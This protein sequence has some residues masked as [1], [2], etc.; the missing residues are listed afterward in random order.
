MIRKQTLFLVAAV[1][2]IGFATQAHAQ[3]GAA[4]VFQ[5]KGANIGAFAIFGP[6]VV[7]ADG[8]EGFA[9]G[10]GF[11]FASDSVSHQPGGP[12]SEFSGGSVD[13]FDYYDS[14]TGTSIGFGIGGFQSGFKAPQPSLESSSVSTTMSVQDLDNGAS[15][16]MSV[17][18][19]LRGEG[20]FNYSDKYTTVYHQLGP[21]TVIVERGANKSRSAGVTG[22][23]TI[24][25]SV[26]DASYSGAS[27]STA[28][29]ASVLVQKPQ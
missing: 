29:S 14:C 19:K 7:C 28:S 16:P 3:Q 8:S 6:G 24:N 25:G 27:M 1:A 21:Y 20:D 22:T 23:I 12:P 17:D 13:I 15:F 4:Q 9:Q 5:S 18:L 2:S 11:V 10:F 26:P